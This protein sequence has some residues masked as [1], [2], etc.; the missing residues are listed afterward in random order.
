MARLYVRYPLFALPAVSLGSG[1]A[2]A[3]L[4]RRAW[5]GRYVAAA[6]LAFSAL[7]T[8]LMWYDRIVYAFKPMV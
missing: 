7:T 3:W 5:W 2:L 8:L 4:V 1:V 6:L